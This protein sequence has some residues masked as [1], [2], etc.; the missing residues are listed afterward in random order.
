M[1]GTC[2]CSDIKSRRSRATFRRAF[3]FTV[4]LVGL[5]FIGPILSRAADKAPLCMAWIPAGIYAMGSDADYSLENERPAHQVHVN[6]FW[7]DTHDVTN[8]EFAKFVA[9]TDYK[10]TA[11]RPVEWDDLK[12]QLSSGTPK[13]DDAKLAPGSLVFTR[14]DGPVDLSDVKNWWRWV[15]GANWQHPEGPGSSIKGRDNFP[16]TQ[17]SW[18]D[19]T[20]YA[21]WGGKRLP[22]EAEWEYAARGGLTG[23]RYSWGDTLMPHGKYMANT[24]TGDFPYRNDKADGFSGLA[25]VGSF[26]PNG[27]GLYDMGGNVWNWCSDFYDPAAYA[28]MPP[29]RRW[30]AARIPP[31]RPCARL[32]QPA[33]REGRLIPLLSHLLRKLSPQCA[34]WRIR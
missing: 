2:R 3:F 32:C 16:V 28:A 17:V 9:A 34:P 33:R 10:T 4:A 26:P 23:K 11:E 31:G 20:A 19:A 13:P 22:T 30:R 12:K 21:K 6:G 18:Y 24:W 7:I 25:P 8:A 5:L 15:P 29:C 27:Y 1:A 14:T